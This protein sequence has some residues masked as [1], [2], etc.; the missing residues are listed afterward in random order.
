MKTLI[1]PSVLSADFSRLGEELS[2]LSAADLIHLDLMDGHYVPNLSYGY[3]LIESI[4]RHTDKPLDAHLMVTN[5]GDYIENLSCLGVKWIS[6]HPETVFHPHRLVQ[7]IQSLG[8]KAGFALNPAT[9]LSILDAILPELDF[10][11]LMSV[12]PGYSAQSFIPSVLDKLRALDSIRKVRKLKF[13][14]EVD[15]G[16]SDQNATQLIKSGADI[17]VSA[18]YI[19]NSSDYTLAINKLKGI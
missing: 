5:P 19:F 3:P 17:L 13:L 7:Y 16:V 1:A 12:N 2:R 9:P 14:I 11:L 10:V 4:H 18:S 6:F 15:G 8:I